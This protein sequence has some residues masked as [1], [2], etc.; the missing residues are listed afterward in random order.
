MNKEK[1]P[2]IKPQE[3][4]PP[5]QKEIEILE[6]AL[7]RLRE[8]WEKGDPSAKILLNTNKQ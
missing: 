8:E 5:T 3:T 2:E 1:I 7:N 6:R 4:K